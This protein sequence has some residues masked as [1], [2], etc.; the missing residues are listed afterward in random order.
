MADVFAD[1]AASL[2]GLLNTTSEIAGFMLGLA[3]IVVLVIAL[4]WALGPS[5]R[6]LAMLVPAGIAMGFVVLVGWWPLW[7]VLFVIVIALV[8]LLKPFGSSTDID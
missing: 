1:L 8:I 2:A 4:S 6:G 3:V 5:A 7:T